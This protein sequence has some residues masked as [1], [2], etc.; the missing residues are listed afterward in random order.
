MTENTLTWYRLYDKYERAE[1]PYLEQ[2]FFLQ[3]VGNVSV[4]L[5]RGNMPALAAEG[6]YLVPNLNGRN[7]FITQDGKYGAYLDQAGQLW[8]GV[9]L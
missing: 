9:Q 6:R 2:T 3:E 8:L 1:V 4:R 7:P 5:C